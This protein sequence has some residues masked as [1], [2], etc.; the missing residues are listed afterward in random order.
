MNS[1]LDTSGQSV[2]NLSSTKQK[3]KIVK[4]RLSTSGKK[5]ANSNLAQDVLSDDITSGLQYDVKRDNAHAQKGLV[6]KD[7]LEKNDV[8]LNE[9]GLNV[10][11]LN[12]TSEFSKEDIQKQ[13][14]HYV[15][16]KNSIT[17]ISTGYNL[18][19]H[20]RMV[21]GV[22]TSLNG[23]S[24]ELKETIESNAIEVNF[25]IDSDLGPKHISGSNAIA[26]TDIV[27][28]EDYD[29]YYWEEDEESLE[30]KELL[31][32]EIRLD[33]RYKSYLESVRYNVDSAIDTIDKIYNNY[34]LFSTKQTQM[35]STRLNSVTKAKAKEEAKYFTKEKLERDLKTLLNY[36]QV[37]AKTATNFVYI[38]EIHAKQKLDKLEIEMK[39]LISKVQGQSNS[40]EAY[41]AIVS[42][43]LQMKDSLKIVQSS[44]DKNGPWY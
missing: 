17:E 27:E 26:Y 44:T 33:N 43:I 21:N 19:S 32:E 38:R 31:K 3:R 14:H 16:S 28:E 39:S 15:A 36:I 12:T 40:Y 10:V 11:L 30:D 13:K 29:Q 42:S 34:I 9:K 23:E 22:L 35:Y 24:G 25:T 18:D 4:K 37:S 8:L 2:E 20:S 5:S 7:S 41:K 1:V 6:L